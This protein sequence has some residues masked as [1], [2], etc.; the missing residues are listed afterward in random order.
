LH[1]CSTGDQKGWAQCRAT[2]GSHKSKPR[3]GGEPLGPQL[4]CE[5]QC[6]IARE[7]LRQLGEFS[8][9]FYTK[10]L[11][12][13]WITLS[14]ISKNLSEAILLICV[15]SSNQM[16]FLA[17]C[18]YRRGSM[19]C[20]CFSDVVIKVCIQSMVEINT[21]WNT[22]SFECAGSFQKEQAEIEVKDFFIISFLNCEK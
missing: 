9:S 20:Y 5:K 15:Q 8:F 18:V 4:F 22:E 16:V 11:V 13:S 10:L 1:L 21:L 6:C 2:L 14:A 3:K 12:Y 19:C 17:Y 7:P